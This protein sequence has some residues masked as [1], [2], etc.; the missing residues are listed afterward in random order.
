MAQLDLPL[1][2]ITVSE[3]ERTFE[4]VASAK[5]WTETK[6][7]LILPIDTMVGTLPHQQTK[8]PPAFVNDLHRS[9]ASAYHTVRIRIQL[10]Y[11]RNKQRYDKE[12]P[13]TLFTVGDQVWLN[14]PV[15]KPGCTK[16]FTSQW[17]GPYTVMDKVNTSD[18]RIRLIGSPSKD[19]VVHHN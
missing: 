8:K 16:K 7:K 6:K 2:E 3:F 11:K 9:L 4:L 17:R 13:F 5:E 15:V 1:P 18:Y 14:V 12:K 10:A 19:L